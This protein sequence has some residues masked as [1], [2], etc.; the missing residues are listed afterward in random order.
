MKEYLLLMLLFITNSM[1][2]QE[3][4]QLKTGTKIEGA[5]IEQVPSDYI[6][7]VEKK[8]RDTLKIS[9][10][11]IEKLTKVGVKSKSENKLITDTSSKVSPIT[12]GAGIGVYG[13]KDAGKITGLRMNFA[14]HKIG[15]TFFTLEYFNVYEFR[16]NND[17]Q[18]SKS[19]NGDQNVSFFGAGFG[20]S[21]HLNGKLQLQIDGSGGVAYNR[22]EDIFIGRDNNWGY[23][24]YWRYESIGSYYAA[25]LTCEY[26]IGKQ[27]AIY[28]QAGFQQYWSTANWVG[29]FTDAFR[30]NSREQEPI[31][32]DEFNRE[33]SQVLDRNYLSETRE[34]I[35]LMIGLKINL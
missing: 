7:L 20:K 6:L 19:I 15:E 5:I 3:V 4:I 27:M 30:D 17:F 31:S 22:S 23:D 1:D 9:Y 13:G 21:I 25:N 18:T 29:Y 11:N 12:L 10:R 16:S 35:G 34:I 28:G 32:S 2:A 26:R 14:L 33:D 24:M 8:K